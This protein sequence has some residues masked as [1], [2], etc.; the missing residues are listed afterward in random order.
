MIFFKRTTFSPYS[1]P[2]KNHLQTSSRA[3]ITITTTFPTSLNALNNPNLGVGNL[4]SQTL[5]QST[6]VHS[7]QC[8]GSGEEGHHSLFSGCGGG[9][10]VNPAPGHS[11]SPRP[12]GASRAGAGAPGPAQTSRSPAVPGVRRSLS[13][14]TIQYPATPAVR[15]TPTPTRTARERGQR[16]DPRGHP[17]RSSPGRCRASSRTLTWQPLL[18]VCRC[19]RLAL[20]PDSCSRGGSG[21][22]AV[23][24]P[25]PP[26][27]RA[28]RGPNP[29]RAAAA[30][31][32]AAVAAAA[33]TAAA[34][35][36]APPP[37]PPP[38]RPPPPRPASYFLDP[39]SARAWQANLR[40]QGSRRAPSLARH[41]DGDLARLPPTATGGRGPQERRSMR[42]P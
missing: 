6:E 25:D 34:A 19:R 24:P 20:T 39:L 26:W 30:A 1:T 12:P 35:A 28:A 4:H 36:P 42:V 27:V 33:A 8:P 5:W 14:R 40:L 16:D 41:K 17:R 11:L 32:A 7:L 31:A 23:S 2:A 22:G 9:P 13:P 3:I 29:V 37:P 18:P 10:K 15:H 21:S 38:R